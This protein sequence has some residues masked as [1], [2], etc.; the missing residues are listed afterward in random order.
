[1]NSQNWATLKESR[2]LDPQQH[3]SWDK[4]SGSNDTQEL[5]RL[6]FLNKIS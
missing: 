3:N 5:K 1:M 6:R 2:L 4:Y